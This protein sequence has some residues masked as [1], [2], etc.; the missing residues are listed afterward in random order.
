MGPLKD[1]ACVVHLDDILVID[2]TEEEH[3]RNLDKV[4]QKLHDA[5][6]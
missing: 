1:R 3:L 6:F 2:A 4:L 5:G